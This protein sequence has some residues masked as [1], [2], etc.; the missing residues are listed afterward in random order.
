MTGVAVPMQVVVEISA[1]DAERRAVRQMIQEEVSNAV[2]SGAFEVAAKLS[3]LRLKEALTSDEVELLYGITART[4]AD[5]RSAGI[6]PRYI[7]GKP[8][9]YR[10]RDVQEYQS[11][12]V[13]KTHDCR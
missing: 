5:Y 10:H 3:A 13:V 7:K 11:R 8:V 1:D 6:G 4:L 2:N 9:R 12:Q